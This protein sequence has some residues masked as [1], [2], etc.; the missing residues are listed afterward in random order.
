MNTAIDIKIEY[1]FEN[2]HHTKLINYE[3]INHLVEKLIK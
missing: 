2:S 3:Q 1:L